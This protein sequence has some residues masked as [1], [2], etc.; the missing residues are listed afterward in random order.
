MGIDMGTTTISVIMIDGES[1][2]LLK[3]KTIPHNAFM[4]GELPVSRI[5]NPDKLM[6]L[7]QQAVGEMISECGVPDSIGMTGQMHGVLYVDKDGQAVSPL[8]T[9]QDGSG[10]EKME[11]GRTY[12]QTLIETVGAAAAGYGLTTHFY[13]QKN[14][15]LS[16][17]A[18]KMT[19]ISDYIAMKLCGNKAPV[20][21]RDMA[22][23]WGCFGIEKGNFCREKL[24]KAGVDISY[25]PKVIENHGVI[26]TTVQHSGGTGTGKDASGF[27]IPG[28]IPVTASLGDNQASVLGSVRDLSDT[29]LVNIG[30]GSQVSFGTGRFFAAQGSIELRPCTEKLYLMAGSGLCGGRAYAMLEQF[31][32]EASGKHEGEELYSVMEA[33]ARDFLKAYGKEGAWKI[34]TTF[35]GTRSNPQERGSIRDIGVENF[36]PGAMTVGMIQ[37]I[38]EELYEMYGEMC[39][40]TGTRAVRL[41]GSG[42]GIRRNPLMREMA[43]ELFGMKMNIPVCKE[44]AAY[45]AAL[46][47]LAAAGLSGSM[48]LMQQKIKYL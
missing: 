28:G 37:G 6:L 13:L 16:G 12:A 4:N 7:V 2:E 30:T 21:A 18:E 27:C 40:M 17:Q 44:E 42:N 24:E 15:R 29:V 19:T 1:G 8:Y 39:R 34:R 25:L 48:A 20:I 43:E 41:V 36:H 38:L 32:R 3:S 31:Y 33:Q 10:N 22:A 47:S 26:G 46:Q 23:S 9:W 5:Q 45:G 11:D 14:G 35:S